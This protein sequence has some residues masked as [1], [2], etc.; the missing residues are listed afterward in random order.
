[1]RKIII[2]FFVFF[3]HY[4]FA[5]IAKIDSLKNKVE[6]SSDSEK[7]NIYLEL[8]ELNRTGS[9]D[10]AKLF[11]EKAKQLASRLENQIALAK[12]Y[13]ELGSISYLQGDSK[14]AILYYEKGMDIIGDKDEVLLYSLINNKGNSLIMS[15]QLEEGL[16][17][18]NKVLKFRRTIQDTAKIADV[19]NNIGVVNYYKGNY[20]AAMKNLLEAAE[21]FDQKGL[22]NRAAGIFGNIA[23]IYNEMG[24][25]KKAI[26]YNHKALANYCQLENYHEQA[27]LLIN[28]A[29]IY[30]NMDSLNQS[31]KYSREALLLAKENGYIPFISL[32][33]SNLGLAYEKKGYYEKAIDFIQRSLEIDSSQGS[34][35]KQAKDHRILGGLYRKQ[36]EYN[37]ALFHLNKSQYLSEKSNWVSDYYD[38]YLEKSKIYEALGA[39]KNSLAYYHKY[40]RVKDS[41]FN[42][43]KH[44]Q[45]TE[46]ETK[47]ETEKKEKELLQL[48]EENSKQK[49]VILKNRYFALGILFVLLVV[50][51]FGALFIRQSKIRSRQKA[52]ELEN[53]LF[54]SQ[55]NPHFIF[56][57]LSAIQYYVTS[58]KPV[59]AGAYLSDFAKLMRLVIENSR[60][61]FITIEQEIDAMKYYLE[62]QKLRFE[63][64]FEYNLDL[65]ENIEKEETLIPPML[66]QPFIENALEHAFKDRKSGNKLIVKYQ[67][68]KDNLLVEVE[69]NGI[70]R[71]KASTE[72]KTSH[73]SFAID[74]TKKRLERLNRKNKNKTFF[75][76]IDVKSDKNTPVG[77]KVKFLL[78]LIYKDN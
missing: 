54:R 15:G 13:L 62:F 46:L 22:K 30:K 23:I 42:K 32:A 25:Y 6:D 44:H 75:E 20:N 29:N 7:L 31:I 52:L 56:N 11:A 9:L 24:N 10:T 76:I 18:Y 60:E 28:M 40:T 67:L 39:Y 2:Y 68:I 49:L 16:Q 70:G 5:Q 27:G 38:I 17:C 3:C 77:T 66:T 47:Y 63:N 78:P 64:G 37:K 8:S 61:E 48:S 35:E 57:A 34:V 50:V 65:D 45:I 19:L 71:E 59:E 14:E 4:S 73:K 1:M 43:E 69:D 72:K 26:D 36:N 53:K 58:N 74:V 51:L 55:M 21:L 41:I 33:Y 12:S